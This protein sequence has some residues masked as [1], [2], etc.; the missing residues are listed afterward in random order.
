MAIN[1]EDLDKILLDVIAT[2]GK[3]T[4]EVK[5]KAG[6][7]FELRVRPYFIEKNRID[8]A[9]LTFLD[10]T[11]RKTQNQSE[12]ESIAKFPDESPNP[13]FRINGKGKSSM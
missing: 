3:I 12:V 11:Q 2:N 13:I 1:I 4:R 5:S 10:I 6:R 7:V 8:G 9:V